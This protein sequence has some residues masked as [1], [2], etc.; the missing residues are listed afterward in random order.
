[1]S[2]SLLDRL[3]LEVRIEIYH[4]YLSDF[5]PDD[6]VRNYDHKSK[7]P[8]PLMQV[9]EALSNEIAQFAIPKLYRTH[10]FILWHTQQ[11]PAHVHLA[12]LVP[13]TGFD[14]KCVQS[15]S[16]VVLDLSVIS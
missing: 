5:F 14:L 12:K 15:R 4:Y 1:M 11:Y 16:Y 3:P 9:S 8:P 13:H 7:L 6:I 10:T 2:L